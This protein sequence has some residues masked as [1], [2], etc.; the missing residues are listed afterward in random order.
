MGVG[1]V[2][3][4]WGVKLSSSECVRDVFGHLLSLHPNNCYFVDSCPVSVKSGKYSQFCHVWSNYRILK[5]WR[6]SAYISDEN[7]FV[8]FVRTIWLYNETH[9]VE[10]SLQPKAQRKIGLKQNEQPIRLD[11][12]DV[13]E[14][15]L[16]YSMR[17]ELEETC[18]YFSDMELLLFPMGT[19]ILMFVRRPTPA[20]LSFIEKIANVSGLYLR[21]HN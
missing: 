4:S 9:L 12:V 21:P 1:K 13:V 19:C 7:K 20:T 2:L 10:C 6:N 15:S 16:R 5:K 18:Y 14:S 17:N 8:D 3:E 11:D